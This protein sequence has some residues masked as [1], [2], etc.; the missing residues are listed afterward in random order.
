VSAWSWAHGQLV[1]G[2][3]GQRGLIQGVGIVPGTEQFQEIDPTLAV[4]AREPGEAFVANMRTVPILALMARPRV[5]HMNVPAALQPRLQQRVLLA[6]ELAMAVGDQRAELPG[7]DIDLPLPQLLKQER[8][9]HMRMVVLVQDEGAQLRA[10]MHTT[11]LG[12]QLADQA[13]ALGGDPALQPIPGV[14]H[15][16]PEL[17]HHKI[18]VALEATV[19]RN[20]L[21]RLHLTDSWMSSS[22]VLWRLP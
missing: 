2:Q 17:L 5:V 8:L 1:L 21:C 4:G 16:D 14:V 6:M 10:E 19:R 9:R 22:A 18:L 20:R 13:H 15:P 3:V 12:R 11:D 7:R